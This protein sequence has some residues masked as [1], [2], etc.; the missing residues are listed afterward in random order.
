MTLNKATFE[1][2][3]LLQGDLVVWMIFLLLCMISVIEV[4]SASSNMSYASGHYWDPVM[5]HGSFV[6]IGVIIAW[7][8]HLIPCVWFK[9]VNVLLYLISFVL[10]IVVLFA[11]KI[12]G[13]ARWINLGLFAFQ[14]SELAKVS[15]IGVSAFILSSMRGEKG[16]T[17]LA[18]KIV[19][20]ATVLVLG[21]IATENLSTAG[22]IFLVILGIMFYAQVPTRYLAW[23]VGALMIAG[24]IGLTTVYSIP[25]EKLIEWSHTENPILHRLPTWVHRITDHQDKPENPNEYDIYDN[26]QVTHAQIAIATCNVVGKGPGNSVERDYLPQAFSDFIYAIIIEEGGIESGTFVMFLYLLLMWRAMKIA[27]RCKALFPAYLVMGLALMM[28][29]QAMI[30]MAVAVGA[31]P[32]TGQPLPL[33]SKGGTSTFVNCAYIGMILSVSRSAK[34]IDEVGGE[35]ATTK[36]TKTN[37][38]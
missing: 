15:L 26:V 25:E 22:I 9:G 2:K 5:K 21:L 13:G 28:V 29:V 17:P 10:L 37:N 20:V 19:S 18:F 11:G 32:V 12:N 16:A 35:M 31:F 30:N 3:G 7:I 1:E 34:K 4:Y 6:V 23:I 36:E 27:K 8:I 14:P 33:I 38:K 24:A